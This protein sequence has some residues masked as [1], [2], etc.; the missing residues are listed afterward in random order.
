MITCTHKR[1]T[2]YQCGGYTFC[3]STIESALTMSYSR[4]TRINIRRR[5]LSKLI[6]VDTDD[7]TSHWSSFR[8]TVRSSFVPLQ[9]CSRNMLPGTRIQAFHVPTFTANTHVLY[10][11]FSQVL[12]P[13]ILY[14]LLFL[15]WCL[16]IVSDPDLLCL[17]ITLDLDVSESFDGSH[18]LFHWWQKATR[19]ELSY[20]VK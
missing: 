14:L 8:S 17:L 15:N 7:V 5:S 13:F 4:G 18:P 1:F 2:R 9:Q 19:D 10:S 12:Q 11:V 3:S 20:C 16:Q 6:I